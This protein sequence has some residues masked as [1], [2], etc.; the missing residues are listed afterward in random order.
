MEDQQFRQYFDS[1]LSSVSGDVMKY[2]T[3]VEKLKLPFVPR[4]IVISICTRA[5]SIFESEPMVLQVKSPCIVVGDIHGHLLDLYRILINYG[6][7]QNTR[8]VFLGDLV[9]RGEFSVETIILVFLLKIFWPNNVYLIRGNHEFEYLCSQCGFSSQ[10]ELVYHDPTIINAFISIFAQIPL[11]ALI[12]QNILCVHGGISPTLFSTCQIASIQRPLFDFGDE[13]IDSLV[14]SDPSQDIDYFQPSSRGTG[15]LF[16]ERAFN[17]F[18]R[19]AH[20]KL[21]VRG[22][23]CVMNGCEFVFQNRLVTVFSASNY[24]GL[25]GNNAGVLKITSL[26]HYEVQTF[27]PLPYLLRTQAIIPKTAI[28]LKLKTISSVSSLKVLPD[29]SENCD[30]QSP[31][32]IRP[33][34]RLPNSNIDLIS[35]KLKQIPESH[36]QTIP[37]FNQNQQFHIR[38]QSKNVFSQNSASLDKPHLLSNKKRVKS[39]TRLPNLAKTKTLNYTL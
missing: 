9:D 26:D 38:S 7:P 37:Q 6:I 19:D 3:G 15:Y 1:F 32:I 25:V 36:S 35:P 14:W 28:N 29:T 22:H 27:P 23:E 31:N 21:L 12:D 10:L 8:Y 13:I 33:V 2:A 34:F 4:E 30:N 18:A 11:A 39:E 16:G 17:D 20:I 5:N 24:C